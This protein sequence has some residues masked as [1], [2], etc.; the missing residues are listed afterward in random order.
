M[1]PWMMYFRAHRP[2]DN[3]LQVSSSPQGH[4]SWAFLFLVNVVIGHLPLEDVHV[5]NLP[6]SV[7][8]VAAAPFAR[9]Y[10]HARTTCLWP[11]F[12]GLLRPCF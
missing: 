12:C 7:I 8:V 9:M 6:L 5:L 3:V 10:H 11:D 4:T 1:Y 2:L